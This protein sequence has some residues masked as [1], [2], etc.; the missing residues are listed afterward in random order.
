MRQIE[1]PEFFEA[2]IELRIGI[3]GTGSKKYFQSRVISPHQL[4]L[5]RKTHPKESQIT[6]IGYTND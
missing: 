6:E 2:L 3:L 5:L 1:D 4:E